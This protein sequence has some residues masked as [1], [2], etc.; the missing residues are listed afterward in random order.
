M[1]P[2]LGR[3]TKLSTLLRGRHEASMAKLIVVGFKLRRHSDRGWRR[4][5]HGGG[6]WSGTDPETQG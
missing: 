6:V 5:T 2:L 1:S 4:A 3:K